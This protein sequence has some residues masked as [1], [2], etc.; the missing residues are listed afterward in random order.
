MLHFSIVIVCVLRGGICSASSRVC[1]PGVCFCLLP[2][3]PV[4][5]VCVCLL[6]LFDFFFLR[7]VCSAKSGS[8]LARMMAFTLTFLLKGI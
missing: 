8:W 3:L 4:M 2:H 7:V 5:L 1:Y 6:F